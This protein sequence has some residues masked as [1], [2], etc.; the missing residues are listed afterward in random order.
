MSA[1]SVCGHELHE[2]YE[3]CLHCGATVGG[4]TPAAGQDVAVRNFANLVDQVKDVSLQAKTLANSANETFGVLLGS[5]V[6]L[7]RQIA[8]SLLAGLSLAS[9]D[10]S[11]GLWEWLQTWL[12]ISVLLLIPI[13]FWLTGVVPFVGLLN[14]ILGPERSLRRRIL[15]AFI[16]MSN[17][18][19]VGLA[20]ALLM[21]HG[22][23]FAMFGGASSQAEASGVLLGMR[24][25]LGNYLVTYYLMGFTSAW[26]SVSSCN[27]HISRQGMAVRAGDVAMKI[28]TLMEARKIPGLERTRVKM[29]KLR[30]YTAGASSGTQGE[31]LSFVGGKVRIVVFVQDYGDGLF[32]RWTGFLEFSGRRLWMLYGLF[33]TV[34]D[35]WTQR[36][37]GSSLIAMAQQWF[38]A[39]SLGTRNHLVL[40]E[41]EGGFIARTLLLAEGVS[42]Y[43][44]NQLYA[45]ESAVRESVVEALQVAVGDHEEAE[46]IRAHIEHDRFNEQKHALS[47]GKASRRI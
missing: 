45:L 9:T 26:R 43:S 7:Q 5:P 46:R 17:S 6:S 23:I 27:S 33:L 38:K 4:G 35:K 18:S 29:S 39:V 1:C 40:R 3:F 31:Q 41:G 20:V 16:W 12:V 34:M 42:E 25:L 37:F 15:L 30:R 19:L 47:R 13:Q 2:G 11:L 22:S 24:Y 14:G 21:G 8:Y 44:W 10:L 28:S 36:W 32:V